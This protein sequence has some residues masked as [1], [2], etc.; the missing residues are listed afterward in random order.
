MLLRI[1]LCPG[2]LLLRG[3]FSTIQCMWLQLFQG[4][5]VTVSI[6][7]LGDLAVV[8]FEVSAPLNVDAILKARRAYRRG[9]AISRSATRGVLPV[10]PLRL[11][12]AFKHALF[13]YVYSYNLAKAKN[14]CYRNVFE[15][16]DFLQD[17][18]KRALL[19]DDSL[20]DTQVL[21][22]GIL[23]T[24]QQWTDGALSSEWHRLFKLCFLLTCFL[25]S[26]WAYIRFN[27]ILL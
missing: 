17:P 16:H 6:C 5:K 24:V 19:E 9:T 11:R 25:V 2:T 13:E 22:Y 14:I 21:M 7:R 1:I 18:S 23:C 10:H 3:R 27:G 26:R 12:H 20:V 15:A 8:L 4:S